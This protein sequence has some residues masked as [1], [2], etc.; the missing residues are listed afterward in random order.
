MPARRPTRRCGARA[1]PAPAT[2]TCPHPRTTRGR[3]S[4][5]AEQCM[6]T[7]VAGEIARGWEGTENRPGCPRRGARRRT[8]AGSRGAR[9]HRAGSR[10][11]TG[12]WDRE[13]R[14]GRRHRPASSS[15]PR[16]LARKSPAW[17]APTA[18]ARPHP[19]GKEIVA[20]HA[21]TRPRSGPAQSTTPGPPG[22]RA[23]TPRPF[24]KGSSTDHTIDAGKRA[25][26]GRATVVY[27]DRLRLR[28]HQRSATRHTR[29]SGC[30]VVTDLDSRLRGNDGSRGA[31][32]PMSAVWQMG[33]F[34]V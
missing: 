30:P 27:P 14:R 33:G 12:K 26:R 8:D 3:C 6:G 19:D 5:I 22:S 2:G 7:P 34:R 29:E 21:G 28:R 16:P 24:P 18:P 13:T 32:P 15:A 31:L 17:P 1:A 4:A 20:D 23:C 10:P 11:R 9:R 25:I